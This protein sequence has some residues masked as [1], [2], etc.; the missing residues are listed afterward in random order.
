[1]I[2]N[3]EKSLTLRANTYIISKNTVKY[4]LS[5][6]GESGDEGAQNQAQE[7]HSDRSSCQADSRIFRSDPVER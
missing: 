5:T 4:L 2:V 3:D 6:V 7:H 1:M